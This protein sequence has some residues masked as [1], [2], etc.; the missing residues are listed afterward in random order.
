MSSPTALHRGA[1][2]SAH[3]VT[4]DSCPHAAAAARTAT[5]GFLA[6]LRPP[7]DPGAADAVVLVVSE[8]VTNA[9]RHARGPSCSLRLAVC[10]DAVA[11]AVSDGCP[12]PPVAR[13]PDVDG[14]RGG[15]GWPMVRQLAIATSVCPTPYGKTVHALLPYRRHGSETA[16]CAE[17]SRPP[18]P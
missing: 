18:A 16:A 4:L 12:D 11:V 14:D 7:V 9:V 2:P 13:R 6:S 3:L 15:F 17:R 1:T 8:L 5:H 10:G